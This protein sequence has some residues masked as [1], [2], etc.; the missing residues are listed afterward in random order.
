MR[1]QPENDLVYLLMILES[2]GKIRIY[3]E[4]FD[5]AIKFFQKNDQLNFNASLLLLANI[6]EQAGKISEATKSKNT[7]I[8]WRQIKNLRNRIVHDYRGIDFEMTFDIIKSELPGIKRQLEDVISRELDSGVFA[9]EE[10]EIAAASQYYSHVDFN[11][12]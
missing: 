2:I 8:S 7:Q 9:K 3:S 11:A 1:P 6:G 4:N 10:F 5:T 12:M